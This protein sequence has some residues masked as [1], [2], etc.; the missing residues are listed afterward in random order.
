MIGGTGETHLLKTVARHANIYNHPFATSEEIQRRLKVLKDHCNSI[1]R[2]YNEIRRSIVFRCLIRENEKE[3]TDLILTA[4]DRHESIP[5]FMQRINAIAGTPEFILKKM[6]EY[7]D[8]G[9]QEFVVHFVSL[10]NK[11]L[12][13]MYSKVILNV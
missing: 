5:C 12:E 4:K 13:L 11:S 6:R 1:R 7:V 9:I 8:I 2:D 3:I 10:D